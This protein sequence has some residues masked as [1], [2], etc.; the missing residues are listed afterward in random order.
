MKMHDLKSWPQFFDPVLTGKKRFEIR[1]DDRGYQIGDILRLKEYI[2]DED[3]YT[4]RELEAKV[5]YLMPAFP[6]LGVM[7]GYCIMS[8][9]V[10]KITTVGGK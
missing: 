9:T 4:G 3:R 6:D 8:I 5:N 7:A 1:K 10:L 2:P